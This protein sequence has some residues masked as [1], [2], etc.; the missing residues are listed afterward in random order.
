MEFRR[1]GEVNDENERRANVFAGELLIPIH[2][3]ESVSKRLLLPTVKN[4]AEVFEVSETVMLGRLKHLN[5]PD[6]YI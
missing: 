2:Q 1:D 3:L 6:L 4:L 5:R